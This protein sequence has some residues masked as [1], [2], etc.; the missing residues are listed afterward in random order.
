MSILNIQFKKESLRSEKPICA[1]L[2][3][4][5]VFP[6]LALN[7]SA[8]LIDDG[9]FKRGKCQELINPAERKLCGGGGGRE[10]R[11]GRTVNGGWWRRSKRRGG[12]ELGGGGGSE[13]KVT[14]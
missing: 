13:G 6:M 14:V 12:G 11:G 9:P 7:F 8:G 4:S 5:E 3:P 10:G 2:R 1:P